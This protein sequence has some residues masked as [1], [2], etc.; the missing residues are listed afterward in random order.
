[1]SQQLPLRNNHT[2]YIL[3]AGYSACRGLPLISGFL[4][5]MRDAAVWCEQQA[6]L[7]EALAI[8]DV[9]VFRLAAAAAAYR[10]P[11]NLE[12]IEELF[13]LASASDPK[14]TKSVKQ[15]IAATI[16]YCMATIEAPEL[17]F[18][19]SEV[20][21]NDL[22]RHATTAAEAQASIVKMPFY[23]ALAIRLLR[24]LVPDESTVITFNYD[25][26]VEQAIKDAGGT[27]T[28]GFSGD[29]EIEDPKHYSALGTPVLKLHG[30]INWAYVG[31]AKRFTVFDTYESV[32]ARD[33]V[34]E[35]VPPTW[36]K[37]I[38]DRLAEV[39]FAAIQKLST[40]TKVVIIGFS[41]PATDL[42]FKYLLAAGLKD[43]LSLREIVFVDPWKGLPERVVEVVSSREVDNNRVRFIHTPVELVFARRTS[44]KRFDL[45]PGWQRPF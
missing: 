4:N 1:M 16:A 15:S 18:N 28:Y 41:I 29:H 38:G 9:L 35:L 23:S 33:L 8:R 14:I 37:S 34:P 26:L 11:I 20:S 45:I 40:A 19:S 43:N 21:T 6:R 42:H 31:K 30:S 2:V 7:S 44:E 12:N 5:R 22:A 27:F 25:D 10:V 3:G 13:S 17:R 36:N 24:A 32:R 39:W